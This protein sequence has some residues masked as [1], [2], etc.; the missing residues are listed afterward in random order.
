MS[1]A[2]G[3]R[4]LF[5]LNGDRTKASSRVRGW[6]VGEELERRGYR[7][8]YFVSRSRYHY[9]GLAWKI[10]GAD[11]VIF[12]KRYSRFDILLVRLARLL[13]KK[14]YFDLDDAPSRV[15]RAVSQRNARR[16]MA[17]CDGVLAGSE[18]LVRMALKEQ[19]GQ[20]TLIPS[21]VRLANYTPRPGGRRDPVP[22]LGWIGT[23]SHY[24][25]DLLAVLAPPLSALAQRRPLR[26]RIVG[27]MGEQRLHDAFGAIE[28]LDCEIVD[29][30][31]WASADAVAEAIAPF[32]IGLYPLLPGPFNDYKCGFKALE[33][34]ALGLPVIA[35][36]VAA[37]GEIVRAGET[38]FVVADAQGWQTALEALID[39]PALAARM[40][41][42]GRARVEE[43]YSI[44]RACDRIEAAI[45]RTQAGREVRLAEA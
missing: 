14:T 11:V 34:M 9:L 15:G 30:I 16:M 18:E 26:L 40:G 13:G 27:G 10:L 7:V 29:Q 43:H 21:S 22:C 23:G 38:G 2:T 35:S 1:P 19:A 37:N 12:Q 45:A 33:Y 20:V 25:D 39:D 42:E 36:G 4:I 6:W 17:L 24:A 41:R 3:T 44:E 31:D 32:D 5:H 28:G 8:V